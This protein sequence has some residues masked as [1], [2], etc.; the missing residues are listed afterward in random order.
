[1][2]RHKRIVGLLLTAVVLASCGGGDD[3]D[4]PEKSSDGGSTT[5][6]QRP[7]AGE[8][9]STDS[10]GGGGSDSEGAL[11]GGGWVEPVAEYCDSH[12]AGIAAV[13]AAMNTGDPSAAASSS[14]TFAEGI[15]MA[16]AEAGAELPDSGAADLDSVISAAD[17]VVAA[18]AEAGAFDPLTEAASVLGSRLQLACPLG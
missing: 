5:T 3:K 18:P 12:S 8:E 9:S 10:P 7:D 11:S 13:R 4:S 16:L 17:A 15:K 1:M 6:L 2:A 14:K